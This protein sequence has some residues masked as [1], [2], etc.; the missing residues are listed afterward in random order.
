MKTCFLFFITNII[1]LASYGQNLTEVNG[2]LKFSSLIVYEQYAESD[3]GEN[4]L[5]SFSKNSTSLTTLSELPSAEFDTLNPKFLQLILNTDKIVILGNFLVKID[6]E[7]HLGMA[8]NANTSNAYNYLKNNDTTVAG[9]MV[10][11]DE[12]DWY[13]PT[14]RL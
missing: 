8:I 7:N 5:D 4:E 6:L 2:T 9:M 14:K 1:N 3:S 12:E 11:T 13:A 10:F